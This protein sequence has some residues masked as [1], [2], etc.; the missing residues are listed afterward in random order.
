MASTDLTPQAFAV[1]LLRTLGIKPNSGNVRALVGWERAEGGHWNNDA[2]FNPL[3]TTQPEPGAG[4]TG[5]Q[6]NIK[7][8]RSWDQGLQATAQTLRNGRYGA[9]IN[10]LRGSDPGAVAQAIGASPWGTSTGLV[11]KTI[12]ST[13][14]STV[15]ASEPTSN[16]PARGARAASATSV[17]TPG[18]DNSAGR[19]AA[20]A[21]FLGNKNASPVDFALQFRAA[22]DTPGQTVTTTTPARSSSG[23]ATPSGGFAKAHSP[24][25]E[26]IHN[27]GAGPGYA[28]KNGQAVNGQQVYGAVWA[29]H[30]DHVHV[31]A[32]PK[33]IVE[34][35]KLAQQMGLHVGEN[36]HFGGVTPVHVP[37]SYHYK[38]EAIDVSGD[39]GKMNAFAAQV[40]RLYGLKR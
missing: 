19:A 25:L 30:R 9:I 15:A 36:P 11:A 16:A 20:I 12:G 35:G 26:L 23:G 5:S 7:V 29:G 28:V 31:A 32:G 2:R 3:N 40:E 39:P 33:T 24:L 18:V 37:G 34:L 13:P 38:G 4:N 21:Q 14:K 10:A 6:G 22:Q 17:T 27:T 1:A 8:Y